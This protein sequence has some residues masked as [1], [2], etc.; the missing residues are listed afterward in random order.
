MKKIKFKTFEQFKKATFTPGGA[1]TQEILYYA[2]LYGNR[3]WGFC[4]S[5]FFGK[6]LDKS[7]TPSDWLQVQFFTHDVEFAPSFCELIANPKT[8]VMTLKG[9]TED[10]YAKICAWIE[11]Q[12]SALLTSVASLKGEQNPLVELETKI[13]IL[14]QRV[15]DN[16]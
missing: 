12:R 4:I 2:R 13:E 11:E 15:V 6:D 10:N 1:G 9:I 14:N 5:G 8:K 7:G 16:D 3:D